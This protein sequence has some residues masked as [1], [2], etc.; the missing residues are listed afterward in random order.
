M[1]HFFKVV[2]FVI[3]FMLVILSSQL[4]CLKCNASEIPILEVREAVS[5]MI[6]PLLEANHVECDSKEFNLKNYIPEYI[7]EG[8]VL[9]PLPVYHYPIYIDKNIVA[10]LTGI[11]EN[12]S[13]G[14][15]YSASINYVNIFEI[16]QKYFKAGIVFR[17][18]D[19][20]YLTDGITFISVISGEIFKIE[21]DSPEYWKNISQLIAA[22][23]MNNLMIEG[24]SGRQS[25]Q[26][27]EDAN[28]KRVLFDLPRYYQ[29]N[30]NI[31]WAA[32][33][34]STGSYLTKD[35]SLSPTEIVIK[36]TGKDDATGYPSDEINALHFFKYSETNFYVNGI[37]EKKFS[38][39]YFMSLLD[40]GIP[41]LVRLS[42]PS[43]PELQFGVKENSIGHTVAA[44]G[45]LYSNYLEE[46][47]V[48]DSAFNRINVLRPGPVGVFRY[49]EFNDGP[50]DLTGFVYPT[51]LQSNDGG[52]T[53]YYIDS[54]SVTRCSGWKSYEGNYY[55]FDSSSHLQRGWL[56][57][58]EGW[59]YL[60]STGA[61]QKGWVFVDGKWYF[62][63]DNGL[64]AYS[65]WFKWNGV[66]YYL[67]S[68]GSAQTGWKEIE[69]GYYFF[70]D[71]A[72]M[73][74]GW[75]NDRGYWF[76]L[77]SS[78]KMLTG[79][80][81]ID[82]YKYYFVDNGSMALG[83]FRVGYPWYYADSNGV[84]Q[85]GWQYIKGEWYYFNYTGTMHLGRLIDGGYIFHLDES[86]GAMQI[87]W[88][89][90]LEGKLFFRTEKN[91]PFGGPKGS[92][93]VGQKARIDG[94]VY[95]F[96]QKGIARK[97]LNPNIVPVSVPTTDL[98]EVTDDAA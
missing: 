20:C 22:L 57:E 48:Q 73:Q 41:F 5:E 36:L 69:G 62:L 26:N 39:T 28:L 12:N 86:S 13:E 11:G 81:T 83:W 23:D 16:S 38:N 96:D 17:T 46:I 44:C 24:G 27:I 47:F 72:K 52:N 84:I 75:V 14:F 10:I 97:V 19:D 88:F 3:S 60:G 37:Y 68:D 85:T 42:V 98:S 71:S 9:K 1:R 78:G 59:Y 56:H 31:C 95:E 54:D 21:D 89:A 6:L 91:V 63:Q 15:A 94:V 87:G 77:D 64:M 32:A 67:N 45:Y 74:T 34:W 61:M 65:Q 25:V 93:V 30:K 8:N 7:L 2:W 53:W 55:F 76:Y 49:S 70:N 50:R 58:S 40:L 80:Q 79:F 18:E 51:G 29:G 4:H 92:M 35:N 66:W 90:T 82:G 33:A 43:I